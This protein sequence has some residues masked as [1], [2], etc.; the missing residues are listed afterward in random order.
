MGFAELGL[1]QDDFTT[2]DRVIQVGYP[3]LRIDILTTIDGV[4]FDAAYRA[5]E[6]V[7]HDGLHLPF[8]GLADLK[9]NKRTVGRAGD[10]DDLERLP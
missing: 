4:D 9:A 6:M 8:I 10:L 7:S 5:R 2:A 1:T 3:P